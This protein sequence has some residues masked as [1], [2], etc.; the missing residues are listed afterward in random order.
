MTQQPI[1][2]PLQI[3]YTREDGSKD[4]FIRGEK[5]GQGGF[6]IVHQVTH[7][8]TNKTY[9]M[10]VISKERYSNIKSKASIEKFQNEIQ[11]QKSLSHINIV[12]AKISFS[13]ETNQYIVLEYCPGKSVREYLKKS[14]KGYLSEPE[15]RK[16]LNDILQGL[17]CLHNRKIIH[18]DLKL[19]NFLIGAD[20]RVKIADFGVS[21]SLK[22]FNEK[23]FSICGT[24][25]YMCPEILQKRKQRTWS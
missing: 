15:T 6:A 11:I 9:A 13:D 20:G 25:N 7:Q 2:V 18:H 23:N 17:L 3:I 4:V 12:S 14:E 5:L 16:I 19:E 1:H 8:A 22:K 10:K 24:P 21:A